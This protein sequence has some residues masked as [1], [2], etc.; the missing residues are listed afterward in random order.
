M[1][2]TYEFTLEDTP[3]VKACGRDASDPVSEVTC[4]NVLGLPPGQRAT[5]C[6]RHSYIN[7]LLNAR[8]YTIHR[9]QNDD[10]PWVKW[11]GDYETK[12]EALN[13]LQI[14]VNR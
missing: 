6:Y 7:P 9:R 4:T 8:P 5:I 14:E 3:V 10:D 1:G 12:E 13:V 11:G 2:Q